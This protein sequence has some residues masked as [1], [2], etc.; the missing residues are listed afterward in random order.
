MEV[1]LQTRTKAVQQPSFT[2]V[3]PQLLQRQCACGQHAVGGECEECRKKR[4]R[5]LQRAAVSAALVNAVPP[6]VYDG[7][8]SP[9]QPL[10][11]EARAFMETRFGYDF[12][13][14]RVHTDPIAAA[15][16][17]AVNALAYTVGR[18][19]VFGM[20]QYAPETND[21]KRLLAHELAHV[22]QQQGSARIQCA[23]AEENHNKEF[24]EAI[25]IVQQ[26]LDSAGSLTKTSKGE[27]GNLTTP[28][29]NEDQIQILQNALS[30]LLALKGSGKVNEDQIQ[31]LQNALSNLLALKGSGKVDEIWDIVKPILAV[32]ERGGDIEKMMEMQ[33][34]GTE[35]EEEDVFESEAELVAHRV[36]KG[37]I[38]GEL[39]Y[40]VSNRYSGPIV[41]RQQPEAVREV[42]EASRGVPHPAGRLVLLVVAGIVLLGYEIYELLRNRPTPQPQPQPQPRPQPEEPRRRKRCRNEPTEYPLPINWP[43]ELPETEGELKRL[44]NETDAQEVEAAE[45]RGGDQRKLADKIRKAREL[46]RDQNRPTLP[47]PLCFD[48]LEHKDPNSIYDA[49]HKKPLFLGGKEEEI[50]LCALF[51]G[52]HER[53]HQKL[54]NQVENLDTY[55]LNGIC[56]PLL[57]D[58]PEGQ[59]YEIVG[60]K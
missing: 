17:H 53:G 35:S 44:Y 25:A 18:D 13:G 51:R 4:E 12:S 10:D 57:Y 16:A 34:K 46:T 37:E 2:W 8:S 50:N 41:Q 20:G 15:S 49:H 54:N 26:A 55:L 27:E 1:Q 22:I 39:T 56:S 11:A 33:R 21:G 59:T 7:L 9:G 58:H 32:T 42:V 23:K 40:Q 24:D 48:D 60:Y 14:V 19:I 38:V 31:I 3:Q 47:E 36:M 45:E 29:V 52:Y 5:T 43:R 30:N 28:V 6:I